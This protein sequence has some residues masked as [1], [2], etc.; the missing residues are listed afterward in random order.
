MTRPHA[1]TTQGLLTN[2]ALI[3]RDWK[4]TAQGIESQTKSNDER[5]ARLIQLHVAQMAGALGECAAQGGCQQPPL[6][7]WDPLFVEVFKRANELNLKARPRRGAV[8]PLR[9]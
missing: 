1:Q 5:V 2:H 8:S 4:P 7:G 9:R 6:R 3:S